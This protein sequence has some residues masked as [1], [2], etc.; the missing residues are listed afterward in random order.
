M[1]GNQKHSPNQLACH[2]GYQ[3]AC[4]SGGNQPG[5]Q[6]LATGKTNILRHSQLG[7][8]E[9]PSPRTNRSRRKIFL[10]K[11]TFL[12]FLS[13]LSHHG[14]DSWKSMPKRASFGESLALGYACRWTKCRKISLIVKSTIWNII[15]SNFCLVRFS[16]W[17]LETVW[18]RCWGQTS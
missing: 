2:L 4:I 5:V 12:P 8:N 9:W 3:G 6:K 10:Q 16:F 1:T 13:R 18:Q 15:D 17:V 11:K 7:R 14:L